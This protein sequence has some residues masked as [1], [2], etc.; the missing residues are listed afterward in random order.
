MLNETNTIPTANVNVLVILSKWRDKK[1]IGLRIF[2]NQKDRG[3]ICSS[4]KVKTEKN[5]V[6]VP[7]NFMLSCM[8]T[9]VSSDSN[10]SDLF[11]NDLYD[12][13]NDLDE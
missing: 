6:K 12:I 4:I 11:Y 5:G 8:K 10:S 2:W 9:K 7:R 3:F 13:G 1:R